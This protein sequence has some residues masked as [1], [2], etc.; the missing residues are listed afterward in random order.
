MPLRHTSPAPS[1]K[2]VELDPGKPRGSRPDIDRL[3]SLLPGSAPKVPLDLASDED[4]G[5]T[6]RQAARGALDRHR[7]GE[8]SAIEI[9]AEGVQD[10]LVHRHVHGAAKP[11]AALEGPPRLCQTLY[12]RQ[13]QTGV[14]KCQAVRIRLA[15][16]VGAAKL[17]AD[18]ADHLQEPIEDLLDHS[19]GTRL[20]HR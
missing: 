19:H 16:P 13:R 10:P 20:G 1:P 15:D 14:W 6:W 7:H 8:V 2:A 18:T 12:C 3:E 11:R 17:P 4:R 9:G 5:F